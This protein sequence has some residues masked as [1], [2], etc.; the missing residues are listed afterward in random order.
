VGIL[1]SRKRKAIKEKR[2]ETAVEPQWNRSGTPLCQQIKQTLETTKK[3][4]G[5][6]DDGDT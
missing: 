4:K 3:R 2:N 1:Y 6:E 5:E